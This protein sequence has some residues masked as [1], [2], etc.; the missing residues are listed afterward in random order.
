MLRSIHNIPRTVV[1]YGE[2][3]SGH[4]PVLVFS[5]LCVSIEI[6]SK[7]FE[8]ISAGYLFY[9]KNMTECLIICD[10]VFVVEYS[11]DCVSSAYKD[12]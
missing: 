1:H 8:Q 10:A 7:A 2:R 4:L 9:S 11:S 3:H 5:L 6:V 12:S